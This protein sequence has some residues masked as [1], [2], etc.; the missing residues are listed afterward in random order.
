MVN[1]LISQSFRES[2]A[3]MNRPT[4]ICHMMMS[5]DG[6]IDCGMTVKLP[7]TNEYYET[8]NALNVNASLSGRVTA[9]LEM[10]LP[11]EYVSKN[12]ESINTTSF[13]KKS[14][15]NNYDVIV[16]T[17][18]TLLWP[19]DSNSLIVI[20]SEN[21]TKEYLAYLDKQNISWIACGKDKIDLAKAVEILATEFNVERLAIV[22]GGTINGGFLDA[23][24][25]DEVS[26]LLGP[27]IDGR[28][29]MAATFDGLPMDREPFQLELET[30]KQYPNG[31]LW[32][33]YKVK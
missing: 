29:G 24:L 10:A 20:T 18:G 33:M 31:C 22:G 16:D 21:A 9:Q 25:I 6:R 30:V 17:K 3:H 13:S 12:N 5:V 28:K 1:I 4:I 11:G 14:D 23:G 15:S 27:G 2:K 19:E 8:L 32:I 7:G 26:I